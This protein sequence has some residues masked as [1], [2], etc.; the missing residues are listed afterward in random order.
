MNRTDV[1]SN[2]VCQLSADKEA[3]A[4]IR[5]FG[6]CAAYQFS[7]LLLPSGCECLKQPDSS[8]QRLW[9][10][11]SEAEINLQPP[12]AQTA[13][14]PPQQRSWASMWLSRPSTTTPT[15]FSRHPPPSSYRYSWSGCSHFSKFSSFVLCFLCTHSTI[16]GFLFLFSS[17]IQRV[18]I[19]I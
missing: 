2:T 18:L 6:F 10:I 16:P 7:S 9:T 13:A 8:P 17:G 19:R 5:Y 3:K 1:C 14:A 4:N 11:L 15:S 12:P